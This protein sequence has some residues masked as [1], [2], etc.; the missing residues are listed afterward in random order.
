[1]NCIHFIKEFK[2]CLQRVWIVIR[3]L[4]DDVCSFDGEEAMLATN[5][6]N[7]R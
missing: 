4:C 7:K 1:M 3:R 6:A 5:I 2:F